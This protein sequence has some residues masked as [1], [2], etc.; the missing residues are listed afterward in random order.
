MD[1][2]EEDDNYSE[3]DSDN[4]EQLVIELEDHNAFLKKL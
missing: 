1:G 4:E 3:P 2:V